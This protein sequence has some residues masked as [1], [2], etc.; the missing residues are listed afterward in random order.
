MSTDAWQ[1]RQETDGIGILTLDVPG[2]S[3]NTL[4]AAVLEDLGR[5]LDGIVQVPPKGL[6][7]RSGKAGGFIAGADINEFLTFGSREGALAAV[8]RGQRLFD[9]IA[10]LP[11]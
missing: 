4:S 6:V 8:L 11:F 2:K 7:I 10:A 1:Y 9:R 3:A 5:V